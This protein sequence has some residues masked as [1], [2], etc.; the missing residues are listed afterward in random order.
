MA[1]IDFLP[2]CS[3][4]H[5]VLWGETIG[6]EERRET[7]KLRRI[8]APDDKPTMYDYLH[9]DVYPYRCPYCNEVFT[10]IAMP[11]D[12]P[13]YCEPLWPIKIKED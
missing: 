13:Y 7:V 2:V 12:L 1:T 11:T 9:R 4:C 8:D 10:S 5:Q 3:H 6:V